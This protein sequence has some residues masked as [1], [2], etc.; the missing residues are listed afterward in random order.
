MLT[1]QGF[2]VVD[3]IAV[4][5]KTVNYISDMLNTHESLPYSTHSTHS[6]ATLSL[7]NIAEH[8]S[9]FCYDAVQSIEI[10]S[11][12]YLVDFSIQPP[13]PE[14]FGYES[15]LAAMLRKTLGTAESQ[16]AGASDIT[17]LSRSLGLR[18]CK[19]M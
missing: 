5:Q 15:H 12:S 3:V 1:V 6:D 9:A 11:S 8:I 18:P 14:V 16:G 17:R 2:G 10:T 13:P 4:T 19:G 7:E